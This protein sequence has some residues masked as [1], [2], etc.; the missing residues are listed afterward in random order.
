MNFKV[1]TILVQNNEI[2][3]LLH[4]ISLLYYYDTSTLIRG[5]IIS[6][7]SCKFCDIKQSPRNS[8]LGWEQRNDCKALAVI[9]ETPETSRETRFGI[10]HWSVS[11]SSN[12]TDSFVPSWWKPLSEL[13]EI[14]SFCNNVNSLN[15]AGFVHATGV[16]KAINVFSWPLSFPNEETCLIAVLEILMCCKQ[17]IFCAATDI[18]WSSIAV[19]WLTS[20]WVKQFSGFMAAK[21][22]TND[23]QLKFNSLTVDDIPFSSRKN[24]EEENVFVSVKSSFSTLCFPRSSFSTEKLNWHFLRLKFLILHL[25][26]STNKD[27]VLSVRFP[28]RERHLIILSARCSWRNNGE[29]KLSFWQETSPYWTPWTSLWH[30]SSILALIKLR[31]I[32]S[33]EAGETVLM[34]RRSFTIQ[35]T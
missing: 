5:E 18:K 20:K 29:M 9:V 15:S 25:R 3:S 14:S 7:C 13:L 22:K 17:S 26:G 12:F 21:S 8:R 2:F 34:L 19:Q 32:S 10:I 27:A 35:G 24:K 28:S 4:I 23:V 6:S 11:I 30:K 16:L 33:R 1:F 31:H